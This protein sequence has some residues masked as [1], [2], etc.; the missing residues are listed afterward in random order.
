MDGSHQA[1]AILDNKELCNKIE[2]ESERSLTVKGVTEDDNN[3]LNEHQQHQQSQLGPQ[4]GPQYSQ[5]G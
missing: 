1:A 4:S 2:F 5:A 3:K